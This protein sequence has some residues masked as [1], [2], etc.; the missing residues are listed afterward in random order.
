MA[1]VDFMA[2]LRQERESAKKRHAEPI[3]A[4]QATLV[5]TAE[6]LDDDMEALDEAL[7]R[8]SLQ[9][10]GALPTLLY[11]AEFVT[12]EEE[13]AL[14][15]AASKGAWVEC[16][17]RRVRR[18]GGGPFIEEGIERRRRGVCRVRAL[19]TP[20]AVGADALPCNR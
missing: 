14:I 4:T 18:I 13:K 12:V 15:E 16:R 2:L 10:V 11:A 5:E 8:P 1:A 19:G 17:G 9:V 20:S 6:A 3:A 7:P